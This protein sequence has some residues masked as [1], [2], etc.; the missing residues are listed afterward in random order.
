MGATMPDCNMHLPCDSIEL[1]PWGCHPVRSGP[2]FLNGQNIV[3]C[4]WEAARRS[5]GLMAGSKWP[6]TTASQ[7]RS[8]QLIGPSV[9]QRWRSMTG[10]FGS[11][12]ASE[13]DEQAAA[14]RTL[15]TGPGHAG[16]GLCPGSI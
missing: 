3:V 7:T 8:S 5:R 15:T 12:T 2:E 4:P 9:G 6:G 16:T 14:D 10:G 13:R 11:A 1:D